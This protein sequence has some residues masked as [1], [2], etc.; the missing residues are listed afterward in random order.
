MRVPTPAELEPA[1]LAGGGARGNGWRLLLLFVGI[2]LPLAVFVALADE[3]HE[4]EALVFDEPLLWWAQQLSSPWL[5]GFALAL[6]KLGYAYGV[7]PLDVAL[8]LGLLG[9]RRWRQAGFASVGFIGSAL[10]NIAAKQFFQRERPSLWLSIAPESTYSFPSGHAM[11]SMTLAAV[12]IALAW[13]TRWRWPMAGLAALFTLLVGLSRVYLGVHYPSDVLGGWA[14]ALLWVV[15]VYL[16]M[17]PGKVPASL[18]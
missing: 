5:D 15:G 4:L 9:L 17:L 6:A 2:L 16:L 7:I 8:V 11:G 13:P 3:V 1:M 14:A 12:L 10:L 18:R